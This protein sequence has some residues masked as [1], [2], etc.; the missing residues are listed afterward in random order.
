MGRAGNTGL[1]ITTCAVPDQNG[2]KSTF[3]IAHPPAA[4]E[5]VHQLKHLLELMVAAGRK[6]LPQAVVVF[7]GFADRR[8]PRL[9]SLNCCGEGA[10]ETV[11]VN[12]REVLTQDGGSE[13]IRLQNGGA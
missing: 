12:P 7:K 9:V 3:S 5:P 13:F 10:L 8:R 2:A 1:T 4:R 11:I 6:S